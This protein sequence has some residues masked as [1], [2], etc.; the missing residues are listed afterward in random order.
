[1]TVVKIRAASPKGLR[2]E[3]GSVVD[4]PVLYTT[5]YDEDTIPLFV[6]S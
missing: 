4:V 1:M 5:Q 6:F 3:I 2:E